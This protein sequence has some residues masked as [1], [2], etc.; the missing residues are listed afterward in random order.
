MSEEKDNSIIEGVITAV[1][2]KN[3]DNGY[4]VVEVAD[5]DGGEITAVGILSLFEVG[6][7]V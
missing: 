2:Y 7:R 1:V 5:D 4:A 3:D 6:E